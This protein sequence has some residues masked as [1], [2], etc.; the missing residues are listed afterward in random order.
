M[1]VHVASLWSTPCKWRTFYVE[2]VR[3]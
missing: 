1:G 2:V 3:P